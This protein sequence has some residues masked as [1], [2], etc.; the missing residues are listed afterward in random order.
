MN[1]I[2]GDIVAAFTDCQDAQLSGEINSG[3]YVIAINNSN[4]RYISCDMNTAG[5]GWLVS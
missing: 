4:L 1:I 2:H 5:G 3:N